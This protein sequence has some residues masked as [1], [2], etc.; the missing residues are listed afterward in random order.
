MKPASLERLEGY[1]GKG[2]SSNRSKKEIDDQIAAEA[3]IGE[4]GPPFPDM[5]PKAQEKWKVLQHEW[6]LI[7]KAS[8][9]DF[10]RL[11]CETWCDLMEA[12][13]M[14]AVLGPA[15]LVELGSKQNIWAVR[16]ERCRDLLRRLLVEV[17]GTPSARQKVEIS[18][19]PEKGG[20]FAG[21]TN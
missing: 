5:S 8:D 18:K 15:T 7:L 17:G 4:I 3:H 11:Y 10:L 20:K 9:R 12:Q 6:A 2:G 19:P 13:T 21:L 16:V 14:V 1:P